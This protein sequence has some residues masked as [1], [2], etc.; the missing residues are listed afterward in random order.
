MFKI[1]VLAVIAM[2]GIACAAWGEDLF[3]TPIFP[4]PNSTMHMGEHYLMAVKTLPGALC[5]VDVTVSG[6]TKVTHGAAVKA[7]SAGAVSWRAYVSSN[8]G[9][10]HAIATCTLDGK[11]VAADWTYVVQ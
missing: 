2:L 7:D 6:L 8:P 9:P 1:S 10:R 11:K 5:S 3:V 4:S